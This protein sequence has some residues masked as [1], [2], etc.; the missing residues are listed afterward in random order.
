MSEINAKT[1]PGENT[2]GF[3]IDAYLK[4]FFSPNHFIIIKKDLKLKAF[5]L[6]WSS[7]QKQYKNKYTETELN[8]YKKEIVDKYTKMYEELLKET[9]EEDEVK[10]KEENV[11]N[12]VWM[13][14]AS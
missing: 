2:N 5:F 12:V 13:D 9:G 7:F 10:V 11:Q 6:F 14:G 1:F 3:T 4:I 8:N